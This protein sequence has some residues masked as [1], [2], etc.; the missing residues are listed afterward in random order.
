IRHAEGLKSGSLSL[1]QIADFQLSFLYLTKIRNLLD[2]FPDSENTLKTTLR[3]FLA[4]RWA[5][6]SNT[7][8]CYTRNTEYPM[9]WAVYML[10]MT[11]EKKAYRAFLMPTLIETDTFGNDLHKL[12]FGQFFVAND[13]KTF[14]VL[15]D[16]IDTVYNKSLNADRVVYTT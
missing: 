16:L 13:N 4:K 12:E 15:E 11:L 8:I 2:T 5:L 3:N 10:A 7:S 14:V 9:N 1:I 6:I